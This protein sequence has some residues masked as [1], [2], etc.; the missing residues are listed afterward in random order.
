VAF[1]SCNATASCQ[2]PEDTSTP[3]CSHSTESQC[4]ADE[5]CSWGSCEV[6]S[7]ICSGLDTE[8]SCQSTSYQVSSGETRT[9]AWDSRNSRC[10]TNGL[11]CHSYSEADPCN[12]DADCT[13]VD[14]CFDAD[15]SSANCE[16][17]CS[18]QSDNCRANPDCSQAL[19]CATD[20]AA[21]CAPV[22]WQCVEHCA[23]NITGRPWQLFRDTA[24]CFLTCSGAALPEAPCGA[25]P[26][27]CI[28]YRDNVCGRSVDGNYTELP[29]ALGYGSP[30]LLPR[31][32]TQEDDSAQACA[33]DKVHA[34][35]L[36]T[37][38]PSDTA[39]VPYEARLSFVSDD[40]SANVAL[41][42][43]DS[44]D[45]VH[46]V[47]CRSAAGSPA[48]CQFSLSNATGD[49]VLS[50]V[51]VTLTPG[52]TYSIT[53]RITLNLVEA[54]L[55]QP[56]ADG[57]GDVTLL[58]SIRLLWP[59]SF[60][61]WRRVG[62]YFGVQPSGA[63][64]CLREYSL[65]QHNSACTAERCSRLDAATC[66]EAEGC[67]A[68]AGTGACDVSE[69]DSCPFLAVNSS[70]CVQPVCQD[71]SDT[72][73]TECCQTA[74]F[75][76]LRYPTDPACNCSVFEQF[77]DPL[78]LTG[79][80]CVDVECSE[81]TQPTLR[82]TFAPSCLKADGAAA[83]QLSSPQPHF[84]SDVTVRCSFFIEDE[85]GGYDCTWHGC[86]TLGEMK[87]ADTF[88]CDV[89]SEVPANATH[90]RIAVQLYHNEA[91][92]PQSSRCFSTGGTPLTS[93]SLRAN[94]TVTVPLCSPS[95][96]EDE[97]CPFHASRDGSPCAASACKASDAKFRQSPSSACCDFAQ[98][99]CNDGN[100][101]DTG[102]DCGT[103]IASS[104]T[105]D[106]SQKP[107]ACRRVSDAVVITPCSDVSQDYT[108]PL[109]F[110]DVNFATL[111]GSDSSPDA[112]LFKALLLDT[113]V[114]S[115]VREADVECI[116]LSVRSK[117]GGT[118][119][120]VRTKSS[121]A[122][123]AVLAAALAGDVSFSFAGSVTTA[124]A[125]GSEGGQGQ[126]LLLPAIGAVA[127]IIALTIFIIF[128]AK[129]RHNE[130]RGEPKVASD[131]AQPFA[132][133]LGSGEDAGLSLQELED[134]SNLDSAFVELDP[135]PPYDP[136]HTEAVPLAFAS[137]LEAYFN[138]SFDTA[139]GGTGALSLAGADAA[140]SLAE[141]RMDDPEEMFYD[142]A[143]PSSGTTMS[144][145]EDSTPGVG[146]DD[147]PA[148][149]APYMDAASKGG[150]SSH[151]SAGVAAPGV[152]FAHAARIL[153]LHELHMLAARN[154]VGA[155][156]RLLPPA[157][158]RDPASEDGRRAWRSPQSGATEVPNLS[159]GTSPHFA[160][161]GVPGS[162]GS[163]AEDK[164]AGLLHLEDPVAFKQRVPLVDVADAQGR[165]PLIWA[166][167]CS[168]RDASAL[169]LHHGA[170]VNAADQKGRTALF[171]AALVRDGGPLARTLLAAGAELGQLTTDGSTAVHAAAALGN[172]GV[173]A[174]LLTP[175]A[176]QAL[177][178]RDALGA[179]GLITAVRC[180][181]R[182]VLDML[183]EAAR[184]APTTTELL[185]AGDHSGATALHW[186]AAVGDT[187]S[188]KKLI[189]AGARCN[190]TTAKD[191][192]P[193]H[194]A[195]KEDNV[196]VIEGLGRYCEAYDLVPLL[197]RASAEGETALDMALSR[198]HYNAALS[199]VMLA[200][201]H[202]VTWG[203]E[204]EALAQLQT[205]LIRL[206]E[207]E[208]QDAAVTA[209]LDDTA[210]ISAA[211]VTWAANG[212]TNPTGVG[213]RRSSGSTATSSARPS[214]DLTLN[215][216][217][218]Q[219]APDGDE[220]D[221]P[222]QKRAK[223]DKGPMSAEQREKNRIDCKQRR[224]KR[225]ADERYM[226]GEV[227][228]LETERD[229][230]QEVIS[231]LQMERALL[232]QL[233]TQ[234]TSSRASS[235]AQ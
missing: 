141:T 226:A 146:S 227:K 199:I 159:P 62:Y 106:T 181:R 43:V 185:N 27:S 198:Q 31:N 96:T 75:H 15:A 164:G 49:T 134:L 137:D 180:G 82:E 168:A 30:P 73:D 208:Q 103:F 42:L 87:R 39:G 67:D 23:A 104:G 110:D 221:G 6:S 130:A 35:L 29:T 200:S 125:S 205:E 152:M 139:A 150:D 129:R 128:M 115:G 117:T 230:L 119:A 197:G 101:D 232:Q 46:F 154:D 25:I 66:A 151:T 183:L 121:A 58:A 215:P 212:P 69:E 105:C 189:Q 186:A 71:G 9:C 44:A 233:A 219:S 165:T 1:I 235:S 38:I 209:L 170:N 194:F 191:E 24:E 196:A 136:A 55:T 4:T 220:Q 190:A 11:D 120:D 202:Q 207:Q 113:L 28:L 51:Q 167:L 76:C 100:L 147:S 216:S 135:L 52:E 155:M 188:V 234:L 177:Q 8:N 184:Q 70:P 172:E 14:A 108:T 140:F 138:P 86:Y 53:A 213:R 72:P 222:K 85:T 102:C 206:A 78:Q 131:S 90:V 36:T 195:V 133:G 171:F 160:S 48:A 149:D 145:I 65:E 17:H 201:E 7:E 223:K 111:I 203:R 57:S 158:P 99:Y 169:L 74:V 22:S 61:G 41:L 26:S 21:S 182:E 16:T 144:G 109:D 10:A 132:H 95:T 37:E 193:L 118:R 156:R 148:S 68:N 187:R 77:C 217:L 13:W 116:A 2:D 32:T 12:V 54:W 231:S 126:G 178:V 127:A 162:P 175:D 98:A 92:S 153:Q 81:A 84:A 19:S 34:A 157:P 229:A 88:T 228:G 40:T 174:A 124:A 122:R 59:L 50:P 63:T 60:Q 210:G 225:K 47:A 112:A 64:A 176:D 142:L 56:S 79:S 80:P 173:L 166:V 161:E 20:A 218:D 211:A 123:R 3:A 91:A 192:T 214:L 89:P 224:E 93:S 33:S 163:I 45:N 18:A 5:A 107:R 94:A 143:S 97:G 179:T 204:P 83:L 114:S